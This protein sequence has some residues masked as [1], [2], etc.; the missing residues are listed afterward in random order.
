MMAQRA[1]LR[2]CE[3]ILTGTHQKMNWH[4]QQYNRLSSNLV[5]LEHRVVINRQ[6]LKMHE[7]LLGNM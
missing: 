5:S 4:L 7:E 2:R 1:L 6:I 3:L